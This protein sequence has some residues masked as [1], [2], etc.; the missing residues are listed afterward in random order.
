MSKA[1]RWKILT[2]E[3]KKK[4]S[5]QYSKKLRANIFIW[6]NIVFLLIVI[7]KFEKSKKKKSINT[8]QNSKKNLAVEKNSK[9]WNKHKENYKTVRNFLLKRLKK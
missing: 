6:K 9:T 1:F 5:F 8:K 2:K 4:F 3:N 7:H